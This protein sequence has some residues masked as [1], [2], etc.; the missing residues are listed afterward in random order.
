MDLADLQLKRSTD[1]QKTG[2]VLVAVFVCNNNIFCGDKPCNQEVD[3]QI[4]QKIFWTK[5]LAQQMEI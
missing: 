5:I 3:N 4:R 1:N 2:R